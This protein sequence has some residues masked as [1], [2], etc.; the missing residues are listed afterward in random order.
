MSIHVCDDEEM[1]ALKEFYEIA[2]TVKRKA[3]D[4]VNEKHTFNRLVYFP[5]SGPVQIHAKWDTKHSMTVSNQSNIL[6]DHATDPISVDDFVSYN[7]QLNKYI[8]GKKEG[9][10]VRKLTHDEYISLMKYNNP[11]CKIIYKWKTIYIYCRVSTQ[12]ETESL[13]TQEKR[14]RNFICSD[15]FERYPVLNDNEFFI[16]DHYHNIQVVYDLYGELINLLN[17][18]DSIIIADDSD[19]LT[20]NVLYANKIIES[21]KKNNIRLMTI[22]RPES[23]DFWRCIDS[24]ENGSYAN[25]DWET[26]F[27]NQV[28]WAQ[29]D[30]EKR[31]IKRV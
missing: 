31:G 8:Y 2:S 28:L 7:T 3:F 15:V 21:I 25:K 18:K 4:V 1:M 22:D 9:G 13:Q 5:H 29:R 16:H 27:L 14:I 24:E 11:Y 12:S 6:T 26:R 17:K 19:R 10:R 20:R 23:S 30:N